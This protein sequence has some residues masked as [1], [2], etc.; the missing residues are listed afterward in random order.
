MAG[1]LNKDV[2]SR[3]AFIRYLYRIGA[4]Q[5]EKPE[6]MKAASILT[7]HDSV[8]L[9][10]HLA[11][12]YTG[13]KGKSHIEF[14]EYWDLLKACNGGQG[15]SMRTSMERLNR[16]RA[17]LKHHASTPSTQDIDGFRNSVSSFFEDNTKPVFGIEFNEISLTYMIKSDLC[18]TNLE[19]ASEKMTAGNVKEAMNSIAIAFL[20]LML[21]HEK[22]GKIINRVISH[23]PESIDNYYDEEKK[24]TDKALED[25]LD[26]FS[27][28]VVKTVDDINQVLFIMINDLDFKKYVRFK[29]LIPFVTGSNG[30][31][32]YQQPLVPDWERTW[33]REECQFCFDFALNT[34]IKLESR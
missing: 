10:L 19:A 4:E 20:E 8:E 11:L 24:I 9:F 17:N 23:S 28:D 18:R 25:I 2:L 1:N 26:D 33:T 29:Q 21:D 32:Y 13:A 5:S 30:E 14:M 3:L 34:A 6:P 7:L 15:I 22:S 16:T 27:S 31:Y 12:E